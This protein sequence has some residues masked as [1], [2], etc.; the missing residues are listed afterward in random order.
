[1]ST[2]LD[3]FNEKDSDVYIAG[4]DVSKAFDNVN[5]YGIFAKLINVNIPLCVL[6]TLIS[7]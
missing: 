5:H 3:Y 6:N 1:M 7:C 2:V 4:L